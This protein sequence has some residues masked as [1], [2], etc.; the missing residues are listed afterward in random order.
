M[1][2][3]MVG[4][5]II[6]LWGATAIAGVRQKSVKCNGTPVDITSDDDAGWRK[7]LTV[8]GEDMIDLDLSGV[9]K[10]QALKSDFFAGTRTKAVSLTYPSGGVLAGTFYMGSYEDTGEHKGEVTFSLKLQSS[11]VVTWIPG[12]S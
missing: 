7:L 1:A 5:S 12:S 9:T 11:G 6:L 4:R 2:N 10:S 3:A 8:S